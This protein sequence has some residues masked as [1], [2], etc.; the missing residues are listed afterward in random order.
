MNREEKIKF[1]E[2]WSK[3]IQEI[4]Y[5]ILVDYRGLTVQQATD[6][7][8]RIR[9]ADSRYRV[10]KNNLA[11]RAIPGTKLES[12]TEHFVGPCAVAY[13][14]HDPVV[15]A[16]T[17]VE[18]AKDYPSLEIKAGVIDGHLMQPGEV[19]QLSKTPGRE[20]LMGKLVYLL[21]FPVQGLASALNNIVRNLAIVLSQVAA[22][23]E[24]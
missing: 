22:A 14:D 18:F 20:E 2:E 4:P 24:G 12:L 10:V 13:N 21:A 17:L 6:L 1:V 5:A 16:K 11:R 15:L 7:R 8:G 3:E 19:E 9:N 23:K